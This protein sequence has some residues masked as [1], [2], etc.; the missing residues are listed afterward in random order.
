MKVERTLE[1]GAAPDVVWKALTDPERTKQYFFGCEA[2]SDW[3]VGSELNYRCDVQ[4]QT[5]TVVT[6]EIR[7]LEPE[8]YLETTCRNAMPGGPSDE[9][10][11][12]YTLEPIASGPRMTVTQGEF[13]D[14]DGA[15]QHGA[16]WDQVLAGLKA[17]V[18]A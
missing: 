11:A 1:L 16:S 17:L 12:T 7:A 4:G 13:P 8:R 10:V 15:D 9:T 3:K 2:V 18:E 14:G 6:G 5:M